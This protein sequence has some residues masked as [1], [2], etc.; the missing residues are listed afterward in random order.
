MSTMPFDQRQRCES[1]YFDEAAT[2][3]FLGREKWGSD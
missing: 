1:W 3:F 2:I